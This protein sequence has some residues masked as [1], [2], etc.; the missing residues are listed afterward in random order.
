M[1]G[2]LIRAA[3]V[4]IM[5]VLLS[6]AAVAQ[7][8]WHWH[9]DDDDYNRRDGYYWDHDRRESQK[10]YERGVRDGRND[11]EHHRQFRIRDRRW[12]DRG[13]RNA[14]LAG[15]R[16]GYG[17]SGYG[18]DGGYDRDRRWGYPDDRR[19]GG[20][21][22]YNQGYQHAYNTGYQDGLLLGQNDRRTG[23]SY[24]PTEHAAY[25]DADHNYSLVGG[26]KQTYKN[27]YRNGYNRG[28]QA[29]YNGR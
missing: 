15:Y 20:S 11:R 6:G 9:G 12:N 5:L 8:W 21:W 25:K 17:H 24:R 1:K 13:D 23:H 4:T 22:G 19:R 16:A 2:S 27:E 3:W 10:W 7:G 29:G 28:Y 26:D 14:Y 18:W